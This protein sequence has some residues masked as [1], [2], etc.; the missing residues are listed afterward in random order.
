[1]L[2]TRGSRGRPLRMPIDRMHAATLATHSPVLTLKRPRSMTAEDVEQQPTSLDAFV[3][4][5]ICLLIARPICDAFRN[6]GGSVSVTDLIAL[7]LIACCVPSLV[8]GGARP[9][10][11]RVTTRL[12]LFVVISGVY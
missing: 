2:S 11:S 8:L 12:L 10:K 5:A 7:L 4:L 9:P 1:M 3:R 6:V